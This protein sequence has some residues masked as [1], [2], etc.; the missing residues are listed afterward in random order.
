MIYINKGQKNIVGLTLTETSRVT[1]PY[2]LFVFT[3]D[4]AK[5]Q[6]EVIFVAPDVSGYPERLNIFEIVEGS[7][8]SKTFANGHELLL[9]GEAH[10]NLESGQY[11]YK[12]YESETL[13]TEV[14]LTTGNIVE[15]GRMVVQLTEDEEDKGQNSNE[16][17]V[18]K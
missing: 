2:Y 3:S 1:S 15:T 6:E 4:G 13:V 12:V 17:N 11:T 7:T 18:Y 5:F 9:E 16:R 8:G 14:A 10:L